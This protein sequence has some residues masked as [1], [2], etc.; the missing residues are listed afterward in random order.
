MRG[1][2]DE[3]GVLAGLFEYHLFGPAFTTVHLTR[4]SQLNL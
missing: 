2:G 4:I 1:H 3:A